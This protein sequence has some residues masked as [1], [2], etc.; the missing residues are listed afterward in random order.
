MLILTW[1]CNGAFRKKYEHILSPEAD[2]LIIQ[3]C[4]NPATVKDS[5][6]RTWASNF[7]WKGDSPHKGL[8]I[9]ARENILLER[10][11]WS[12]EYEGLN[13]K[14]F[15][16][17]RIDDRFNLLGV[18]T[19]HN[20][21]PTFGYIGQLWKYMQI[22]KLLFGD[23]II[24][25]DFNSNSI[26]DHKDRW[27][28]HCDVVKEL[29]AFEIFSAYHLYTAE[30]HGK[31]SQPTFFLHRNENKPYHLDYLFASRSRLEQG[32]HVNVGKYQ[33]WRTYS[34]HVPVWISLPD[35]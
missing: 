31:E 22:N 18:W 9:F 33:D 15:L 14:H 34:D 1:N 21:S 25:G 13:V 35:L 8:G 29:A 23:S 30:D 26:W 16:P 17:C 24:A 6:F 4:E 27:W 11:D 3:E 7:L 2:I 32:M 10:L 19:H 5:A 20:N 12:S 28:N